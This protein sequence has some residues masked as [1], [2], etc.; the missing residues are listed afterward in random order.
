M[1][2][3]SV[4]GLLSAEPVSRVGVEVGKEPSY[5]ATGRSVGKATGGIVGGTK[6]ISSTSLF[7]A[8]TIKA[9]S[10]LT[11]KTTH[12][13]MRRQLARVRMLADKRPRNRSNEE[14]SG[15]D[16]IIGLLLQVAF[17]RVSVLR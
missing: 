9:C 11:D 2:G 6:T 16:Q 14:T 1:V 15:F 10:E 7:S 17:R 3:G 12:D 4:G 13:A 8:G 5:I